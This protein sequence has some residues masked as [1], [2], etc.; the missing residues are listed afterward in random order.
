MSA[1]TL[2]NLTNKYNIGTAFSRIVVTR[3]SRFTYRGT[4]RSSPSLVKY[5]QANAGH[6][7]L[8]KSKKPLQKFCKKTCKRLE[9]TPTP[10]EWKLYYPH[11]DG[12]RKYWLRPNTECLREKSRRCRRKTARFFNL[13]K[14]LYSP[15]TPPCHRTRLNSIIYAV[16][17]FGSNLPNSF[18]KKLKRVS[19][20]GEWL[21]GRLLSSMLGYIVNNYIDFAVLK[22][23]SRLHL[24]P[25]LRSMLIHGT[26]ERN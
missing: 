25:S 5:V 4:Y 26:G 21:Q 1:K 6:M 10:K 16:C 9:K 18:F 20:S 3:K 15:N 7:D 23:L 24:Q 13:E 17:L 12:K 2:I 19:R 14:M 22:Q 8:E 11:K